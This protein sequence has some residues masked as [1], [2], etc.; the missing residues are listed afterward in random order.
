MSNVT[1]LIQNPP[2]LTGQ[3]AIDLDPELG[4]ELAWLLSRYQGQH[5]PTVI[6]PEDALRLAILD[7]ADCLHGA[8]ISEGRG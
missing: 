3:I 2:I 1:L 7:A 8:E 5:A 6:T 4:R